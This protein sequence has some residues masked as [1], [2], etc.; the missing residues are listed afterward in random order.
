MGCFFN[1]WA[2]D[3]N[4]IIVAA[5]LASVAIGYIK[6]INIGLLAIAFGYVIGV[7]ALDLTP[8]NVIAMWPIHFFFL[9]FAICLFY[10]FAVANGTLDAV[11]RRFVFPARDKP[12]LIPF[13]LYLTCAAIAGIGPGAPAVFA[14]M[15]PI[16]MSVAKETGMK[17]LLGA[18]ILVAGANTGAWSNIAVNG[19]ITRGL[20]EKSGF[21]AQSA[22]YANRVWLN[23]FTT[24]FLGLLAA[25]FLLGGYRL[26]AAVM[27]RPQALTR[28]QKTNL[29][30]IAFVVGCLILPLLMRF[31]MPGSAVIGR[32]AGKMDITMLSIIG[33]I[34]ALFFGIGDEKR[35]LSEV[36]WALIV[37]LCGVGVLIEV[38]VQAGTIKLLSTV[39]SSNVSAAALPHAMGIVAFSMGFFSSVLGV[40]MPT[41]YPLVPSLAA[42]IGGLGPT[43]LFSIV[44]LG[45]IASGC[46]PFSTAGALSIA[47]LRTEQERQRLFS[48]LL[49]APAVF[50]L[51]F[52]AL[53]ALGVI[54]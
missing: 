13:A 2:M 28:D 32:I 31:L 37:L 8:R 42:N 33:C 26:K 23:V 1:G 46:S 35:A 36:P 38:A 50:L 5:I 54:V 9:L 10:G 29:G 6:K 41:L 20:I 30:I 43:V 34:L 18:V 19:V 7:F 17:P 27:E 49:F 40:V 21:A 45:G 24:H 52:L 53:L 47:G 44:S 14:L 39:V 3:L 48:Q 25:Y 22:Q 12:Y 4:L 51:F 16:I 15:G 11:A